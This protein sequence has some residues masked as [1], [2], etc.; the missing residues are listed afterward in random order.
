MIVSFTG[1]QST[2]KSTLFNRLK[3]TDRFRRFNFVSEI[4]RTLKEDYNLNIN[5]EGN[6]MT[7]LAILNSHFMNYLKYKDKDVLL[8]RCILDGLVYTTYLYYTEKVSK[9]VVDYAEYITGLLVN[10]IDILYYTEADVPLVDDGERSVNIEFRNKILELFEEAIDHYKINVVR[11]KGSVE[12]RIKIVNE[13]F[14]L[15]QT[16]N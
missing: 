13:K 6:D 15:W 9:Q 8:D 14:D 16:I 10:K 11:L 12:D 7:Q 3:S 2:G 4:T 1:A 5:E